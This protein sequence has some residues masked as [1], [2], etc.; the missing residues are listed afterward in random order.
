[1]VYKR[2][3]TTTTQTT[4]ETYDESPA[5]TVAGTTQPLQEPTYPPNI[6]DDIACSTTAGTGDDLRD[7]NQEKPIADSF[8]RTYPD[9]LIEFIKGDKHISPQ[10]TSVLICF[11]V[12]FIFQM[13][14]K[15]NSIDDLLSMLMVAVAFIVIY[16]SVKGIMSLFKYLKL[17]KN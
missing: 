16:F 6:I 13:M 14:G 17:K 10:A 12:L 2:T 8:G 11:V 4:E 1:M 3:V 5:A 15:L 9:L 7:I